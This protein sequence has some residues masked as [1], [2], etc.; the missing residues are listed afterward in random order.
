MKELIK[1]I[2]K[3]KLYFYCDIFRQI[4]AHMI[5]HPEYKEKTKIYLF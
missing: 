5:K 3:E 1:I 2:E 4:D